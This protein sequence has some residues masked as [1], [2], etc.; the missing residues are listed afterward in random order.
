MALRDKK[1]P[2]LRSPIKG[3]IIFSMDK[4]TIQF[5]LVERALL[6][7]SG[8]RKTMQVARATGRKRVNFRAF[9]ER[10]S[11]SASFS[12]QE[13]GAIFNT[14]IEVARDIVSEGD[15][16]ELG[17]FGTLR[18]SFKSKAIP[19]GETFRVQEHILAPKVCFMPN[20][21]FFALGVSSYM[22]VKTKDEL[23]AER[24]HSAKPKPV[25][26]AS[27]SGTL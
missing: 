3:A 27:S 24:G 4:Q 1:A 13:V 20:R 26:G 16:V 25:S 8:E 5:V 15:I 2:I 6:N 19:K 7:K 21:K 11:K 18:P 9:C 10:V 14:A 12:W 17:D 23:R 22:Q